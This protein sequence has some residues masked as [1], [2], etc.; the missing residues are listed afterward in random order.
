MSDRNEHSKK[1]A[2]YL[3]EKEMVHFSERLCRHLIRLGRVGGSLMLTSLPPEEINHLHGLM[4]ALPGEKL[5]LRSLVRSLQSTV[6]AEAD[7]F[8]AMEFYCGKP[9]VTR[10]ERRAKELRDREDFFEQLDDLFALPLSERQI[11]FRER[12]SL[13]RE[14]PSLLPAFQSRYADDPHKLR[15]DIQY[16]SQGLRLLDAGAKK[17]YLPK[18]SAEVTRDPHAFDPGGFLYQ[19]LLFSLEDGGVKQHI[20]SRHRILRDDF[21]N[22]VLF[23]GICLFCEKGPI[24]FVQQAFDDKEPLILPLYTLKQAVRAEALDAKVFMVENAAVFAELFENRKDISLIFGQGQLRR[25]VTALLELLF[26]SDVRLFYA[27]DFDPEGLLIAQGLIDRYGEKVSLWRMGVDDYQ[28][29]ISKKRISPGRMKKLENLKD[30]SLIQLAE[31]IK[32]TSLAGYQENLSWLREGE[33][34]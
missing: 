8:L 1:L 30:P 21:S 4:G 34:E 22:Q 17:L 2:E 9:L 31:V 7:L 12:L 5:S 20:L 29:A 14:N 23:Y 27:G 33:M 3:R 10:E 6:F 32:E 11:V 18:F 24:G 26:T 15:R 16:V 25:A 28:A 19:L 13:L